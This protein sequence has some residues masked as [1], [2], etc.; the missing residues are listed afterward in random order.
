MP[1]FKKLFSGLGGFVLIAVLAIALYH[2]VKGYKNKKIDEVEKFDVSSSELL[3]DTPP[4]VTPAVELN[5]ESYKP[6]DYTMSTVSN[7]CFP[8]SKLTAQDLLPSGDAANS[9]WAQTVPAG[10]GD[11]NSGALLNATYHY[12]IDTIGSTLKN[13]NLDLRSEPI[14]EKKSV[15]PWINSS[16]E[17][18]LTRRPLEIGV[19]A[20]TC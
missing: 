19:D 7:D 5:N 18:D 17:P 1:N 20:S 3:Q 15:S 10:Q 14:I 12:G 13:P 6:I 11:V 9:D 16:Y 8:S 4:E 2:V